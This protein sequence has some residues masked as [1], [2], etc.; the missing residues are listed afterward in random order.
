M[1]YNPFKL[2]GEG[3]PKV[4]IAAIIAGCVILISVVCNAAICCHLRKKQA[5]KK[6]EEPQQSKI[7]MPQV[8]EQ[9]NNNNTQPQG[10]LHSN[11]QNPVVQ[12]GA[13]QQFIQPGA[14]QFAQQP[15]QGLQMNANHQPGMMQNQMYGQPVIMSNIDQPAI[16]IPVYQNQVVYEYSESIGAPQGQPP[17]PKYNQQF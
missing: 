2:E 13:Q 1:Q 10:N 7:E 12:P 3:L 16:G 14:Q 8:A 4:V 15:Y 11:Q 5:N 6:D 9:A 17:I